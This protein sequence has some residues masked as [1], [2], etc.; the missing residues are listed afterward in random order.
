MP[1][2]KEYYRLVNMRPT[3]YMTMPFGEYE[4][5]SGEFG[6]ELERYLYDYDLLKTKA[7]NVGNTLT[8]YQQQGFRNMILN[9]ILIAA[10]TAEKELEAQEARHIARPGLFSK[11]DEAKAA[12]ALSLTAYQKLKAIDPSALPPV[13]PGTMTA[14]EIRKSL[15]DA[16]DRSEDL[17]PLSYALI[18]DVIAKNAYQWTSA[19]QSNIQLLP[20]TG[21]STQAVS[22]NK[23]AILKYVVNTD[24]EGDARFTIGAI[25]DYTNQK[26]DMRISVMIDD[27]EPITISLKDAYNHTNWKMDIW[28]GQTR[29]S[30]FT[31]LK[32]GNHV[33]EIKA[34]DDHI[35]LDQWILDFDVDREYYVIPVR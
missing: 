29:K 18:K 12:A 16:F 24:M 5:H 1:L 30:F 23:G 32:K 26:G 25:P 14:A 33:V 21:H 34:L 20:F 35:I 19:T 4:F 6:N 3:G 11:D 2:M 7:T 17:K 10:L 13:L 9:P 15:Q 28:R 8:A 31:T 27:Q 22:M